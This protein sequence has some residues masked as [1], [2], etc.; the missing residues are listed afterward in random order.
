MQTHC[1]DARMQDAENFHE[2]KADVESSGVDDFRIS[3]ERR[4]S[5]RRN[6]RSYQA[7]GFEHRNDLIF[8]EVQAD[9]DVDEEVTGNGF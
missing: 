7:L 2:E 9:D 5:D 1:G 3:W 4:S 8:Q 6:N